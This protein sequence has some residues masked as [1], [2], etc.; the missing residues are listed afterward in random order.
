[1]EWNKAAFGNIHQVVKLSEDHVT[2]VEEAYDTDP[3]ETN[4]INL[5]YV[6]QVL[7]E[8][9][10]EIYFRLKANIKWTIEG[11]RN[12]KFFHQMVQQRRQKL[13]L[14]GIEDANGVQI[15]NEEDIKK[16]CKKA[17]HSQL[18]GKRTIKGIDY[19]NVYPSS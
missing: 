16:E 10:E 18:N 11:D 13:Y 9:L 2:H 12:N 6:K 19:C 5:R 14:H 17:F 7:N 1:M 15:T 3:S 8:Q 4:K